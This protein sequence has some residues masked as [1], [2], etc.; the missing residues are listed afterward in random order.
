[1]KSSISRAARSA[2]LFAVAALVGCSGADVPMQKTVKVSGSV[3]LDGK[4]VEGL[5]IRFIPADKTNFKLDETPLGRTDAAGK[6][7]LTTYYNGDGAPPG[8]YLVAVSYPD[9]VPVSEEAD[10]TA[11]AIA[12]AKAKKE[13][14]KDGKPRFPQIYQ[15]PQKSGL[16]ATVAKGGGELPPFELS[17]AKK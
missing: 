15:V 14:A 7:T 2:T 16:V 12:A 9:Q 17:S 11:T 1:M 10:E 8:D 13:R 5:D 6:F 3:L 4:L